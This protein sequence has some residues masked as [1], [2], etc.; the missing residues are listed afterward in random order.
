MIIQPV[1]VMNAMG[2]GRVCLCPQQ[3]QGFCEDI[4]RADSIHIIIP[5][6]P[7]QKALLHRVQDFVHRLFHVL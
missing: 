6:D 1:S 2:N 4:R 3:L 7:D 5:D